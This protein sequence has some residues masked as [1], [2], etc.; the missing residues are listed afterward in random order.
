MGRSPV[1]ADEICWLSEAA[2]AAFMVSPLLVSDMVHT[3]QLGQEEATEH[4]WAF[5]TEAKLSGILNIDFHTTRIC[6]GNELMH[7][8]T[9]VALKQAHRY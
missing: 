6:S 7:S 5:K 2:T 1:R 4:L 8:I 9:R 3:V